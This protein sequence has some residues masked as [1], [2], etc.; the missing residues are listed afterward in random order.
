MSL[1]YVTFEQNK[2]KQKN[3]RNGQNK[4]KRKERFQNWSEANTKLAEVA[5]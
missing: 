5:W 2:K 3:Q 1:V 4:K